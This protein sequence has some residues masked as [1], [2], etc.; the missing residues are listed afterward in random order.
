MAHFFD[1]SRK[2]AEPELADVSGGN[3]RRERTIQRLQ[4][5][6]TGVVLMILL[7]GLASVIQNRAAETDATAVPEAAATTEPT[8]IATQNDPLVEAGVVPDMPSQ[9]APAAAAAPTPAQ[10]DAVTPGQ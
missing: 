4:I 10:S 2:P 9:P 1:M 7:V 8:A 3:A 6:V 5:G